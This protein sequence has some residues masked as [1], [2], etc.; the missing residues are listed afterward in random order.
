MNRNE[1]VAVVGVACQL[2]GARAASAFWDLLMAER[3]AVSDVCPRR[4]DLDP[5]FGQADRNAVRAGGFVDDVDKFDAAFFN[6]AP[7]VATR[8]D[9]QQRLL[10][11]SVWEALEDA[12][13]PAEQLAGSNT[14]V[15]TSCPTSGYWD[16][17]R[18]AGLLD[19][20]TS[21]SADSGAAV[22]GLVSHFLDL[23]GPNMGVNAF[24]ASSLL[25]AHFAYRAVR[26][27]DTDLAIVG[28]ANLTYLPTMY[29]APA[30]DEMLSPTGRCRFGDVRADGYV[31]AEGVV[32]LVFKPYRKAVADGDRIYATILGSGVSSDGRSGGTILAP[33]V[34]GQE[35]M[36]RAA[37]R[38]A[39]VAPGAVDY[40]EAHGAGTPVG[41]VAEL[42]ALARVLGEGRTGEPCRV[43]SV[44]SNIGH[45]AI[46]AGLSGLLKTVLALRHGTIPAT[47]HVAEQR[48]MLAAPDAPIRL[49]TSGE[50]WPETGR[51]A[52][53]GVS[54]FGMTGTNVHLVLGAARPETAADLP[55]PAEPRA[56]LLPLSAHTPTA[57]AEL[58]G[59]YADT[60]STRVSSVGPRDVC[61][62][63][64]TRRTHHAHRAAF[65]GRNRQE[66]VA[67]LRS[68]ADG[69]RPEAAIP[70]AGRV[71]TPPRVVFVFPGQG[72]QWPGMGRTLLATNDV[73]AERMR[74][75]DKAV[76]A[77]GCPSPIELLTSGD[78]LSAVEEIQPTLWA[79]QVALAEVWR[80]YGV[81]C[82]QVIGHS[83]GEIAAAV[84]TGA[85]TVREGA[86]VVCRRSLL[87]A[88][89][90]TPGA[91]WA[92]QTGEW[93]AR[94][95]IAELADRVEVGV[96]NSDHST[97]LSGDPEAVRTVV[98]RLGRAGVYCR[99]VQVDYASHCSGMTPLRPAL[100][101]SLSDLA[102][103][104][105]RVPMHSTVTGEPVDGSGCDG[106]YWADNLCRPV[107]FADAVRSTLDLPGRTLFVEISPHP[108]LVAAIQDGIDGCA[109]AATVVPTLVR[110]QPEYETLLAGLG[111]AYVNGCAPDWRRIA[112][113]G[114]FVPLPRYPW[115][116]KRFW[117][118][119]DQAEVSAPAP[120]VAP[121]PEPMVIDEPLDTDALADR[122]TRHIAEV[123]AMSPDEIDPDIPLTLAGLD[124]VLAAKLG[125]RMRQE[126]DVHLPVREFLGASSLT[127][128]TNL[129]RD[130]MPATDDAQ[131][132]VRLS[133][134]H[135]ARPALPT[136]RT[137]PATEQR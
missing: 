105:G 54:S 128:L 53:A 133:V 97:V 61:F 129:V 69:G 106:S 41:D 131:A 32:S 15:Y 17:L 46:A 123:L 84:V 137:T 130:R 34:A 89:Q 65:V 101:E 1:P 9:P 124:S 40:V 59:S 31:P 62:S 115:Q 109:G 30:E 16:L 114:R 66:L 4:V 74:E 3:D 117:I 134:P 121:P 67:A 87:L 23:R 10:L 120:V 98:D 19:V 95:A 63:A 51:P 119:T 6:L 37:Y 21:F 72:A 76:V 113:G 81:D 79:T 71:T 56:H 132:V 36:L 26:D 45:T 103:R 83:M 25:A 93:G 13:I 126:L 38:D 24:C 68:Y 127:D 43:G 104:P 136:P 108:V 20:Y 22:A 29:L 78:E 5:R 57:L 122:V 99:R 28:A 82:D 64:G 8:L 116:S 50:P 91:M 85:L 49:A 33:G 39:G 44:K 58:A 27:G 55:R 12:G 35:G 75:C 90:R 111:T 86:A 18:S 110:D 60:L 118:D 102:P 47:L 2:P 125:A 112:D 107:R 14:G 42:T 92:V 77:E 48:P 73:F 70:P 52:V 94:V 11:Q 135:P 88:G 100:I 96:V 80:A 7:R